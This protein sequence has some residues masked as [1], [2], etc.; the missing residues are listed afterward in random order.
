MVLFIYFLPVK[1]LGADINEGTLPKRQ[2]RWVLKD[3]NEVAKA[4]SKVNQKKNFL[5][6]LIAI[7]QAINCL[8]SF[9]NCVKKVC[10]YLFSI[11]EN[12]LQIWQVYF[13]MSFTPKNNDFFHKNTH[14]ELDIWE[15]RYFMK[16]F[17]L[18]KNKCDL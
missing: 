5:K 9:F 6:L 18:D 8:I 16:Y 4:K 15:S 13:K 12:L 7:I 2:M 11:N 10:M 14:Y 3:Y 1:N 17:K